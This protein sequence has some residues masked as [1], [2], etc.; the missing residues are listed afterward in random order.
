MKF[1]TLTREYIVMLTGY[2]FHVIDFFETFN[3]YLNNEIYDLTFR[4]I[5]LFLLIVNI[6]GV[7]QRVRSLLKNNNNSNQTMLSFSGAE[8]QT[9]STVI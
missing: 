1:C 5:L 2:N 6:T 8:V 4:P 9:R 3:Y 7:V